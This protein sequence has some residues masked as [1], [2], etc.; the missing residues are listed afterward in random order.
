LNGSRKAIRAWVIFLG[1]GKRVGEI[2]LRR[3]TKM[4]HTSGAKV[5]EK[6]SGEEGGMPLRE[7]RP[8]K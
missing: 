6:K 1:G 4:R 2:E 5:R 3:H 8:K 7:E